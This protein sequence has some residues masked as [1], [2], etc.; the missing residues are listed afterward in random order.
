[1]KTIKK[2]SAFTA[3]VLMST[4]MG[5]AYAEDSDASQIRT[6]DRI[7]IENNLQAPASDFGQAF[8]R[9]QKVVE[10]MEQDKNQYRY[11][12]QHRNN[13]QAQQPYSGRSSMNTGG[14]SARGKR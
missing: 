5:A 11:E 8:S 3:T 9:D 14:S 2:L 4:S 6:Q 13:Y 1:L 7:R 12:Y 10:N